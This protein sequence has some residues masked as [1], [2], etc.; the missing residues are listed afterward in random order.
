MATRAWARRVP[1]GTGMV[2][3][4]WLLFG[5]AGTPGTI[6]HAQPQVHLPSRPFAAF[7]SAVLGHP[8]LLRAHARSPTAVGGVAL[9]IESFAPGLASVEVFDASGRRL[10]CTPIRLVPPRVSTLVP[11]GSGG[12]GLSPG[13]YFI[14]VA[15]GTQA[16]A[17]R[18]VF[19]VNGA[20]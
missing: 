13:V 11:L 8:V 10:S 6:Q 3:A 1:R 12:R 4:V 2:I 20:P 15:R 5:C 14:R 7:D 16:C 19:L 9:D 18:V 17:C